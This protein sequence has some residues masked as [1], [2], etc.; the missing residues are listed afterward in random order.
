MWRFK[1]FTDY[2]QKVRSENGAILD[3]LYNH[4]RGLGNSDTL[5]DD[6]TILEVAFN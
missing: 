1:E 6:F 3:R 4:V 2:L 5:E